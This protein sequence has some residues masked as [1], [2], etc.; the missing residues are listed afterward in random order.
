MVIAN[1]NTN[2]NTLISAPTDQSTTMTPSSTLAR[3]I[4]RASPSTPSV[5]FITSA[6]NTTP[7]RTSTTT[8]SP[9]TSTNTSTTSSTTKKTGDVTP[10]S[11]IL[12]TS[13]GYQ[14]IDSIL[15]LQELITPLVTHS[16]KKTHESFQEKQSEFN[17][18]ELIKIESIINDLRIFINFQLSTFNKIETSTIHNKD[19]EGFSLEWIYEGRVEILKIY[20]AVMCIDGLI[21]QLLELLDSKLSRICG[22]DGNSGGGNDAKQAH[23]RLASMLDDLNTICESSLKLRKFICVYKKRLDVGVQY[24]ELDSSVM[25]S[26]ELE[27]FDCEKS[28]ALLHTIT[29]KLDEQKKKEREELELTAGGINNNNNKNDNNNNNTQKFEL[30]TLIQEINKNSKITLA[31]P[32]FNS[33]ETQQYQLFNDLNNKISPI[34][35]SIML[36][37][38]TIEQYSELAK[39]TYSESIL[40]LIEK[41]EFMIADLKKINDCVRELRVKLVDLKW[42][43]IFKFLVDDVQRLVLELE[44]CGSGVGSGSRSVYGLDDDTETLVDGGDADADADTEVN[45]GGG[46]KFRDLESQQ[47]DP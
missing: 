8:T 46:N 15:S 12:S 5:S 33:L 28:I 23:V 22:D 30:A 11:T 19:K 26:I 3:S 39:D 1:I 25:K 44:S 37:P 13:S 34:N 6:L 38:Q 36:I 18:F 14:R 21:S 17:T 2:T 32:T 31:I 35:A 16:N 9:N 42:I 20:R 41:Y 47:L 24:H 45:V 10:L 7:T 27:L 29:K 40:K 4:T 43:E